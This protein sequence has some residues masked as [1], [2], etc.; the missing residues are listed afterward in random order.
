MR[1]RVQ[2]HKNDVDVAVA[3]L[4]GPAFHHLAR[5]HVGLKSSPLDLPDETDPVRAIS[6]FISNYIW[7]YG[8]L[9]HI[10]EEIET[11][12][13]D[14]VL[15]VMHM[16]WAV[17]RV[18]PL[19]RDNVVGATYGCLVVATKLYLDD[20]RYTTVPMLVRIINW[21]PV[22][23]ECVKALELATFT[24]LLRSGQPFACPTR[25]GADSIRSSQEF[26][27]KCTTEK[28]RVGPRWTSPVFRQV[29]KTF[30]RGG[31]TSRKTPCHRP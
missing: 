5:R 24:A 10:D 1:G 22:D 14:F 12:V 6:S 21:G 13:V 29:R 2:P 31:K 25:S 26:P 17:D 11:W 16:M 30:S 4:V 27:T 3:A 9:H 7:T 8:S 28:T 18:H 15:R 23:A 19:Y 20:L